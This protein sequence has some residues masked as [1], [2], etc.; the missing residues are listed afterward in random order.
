[1]TKQKFE[2]KIKTILKSKPP[3][4]PK[5]CDTCG[6]YS[7]AKHQGIWCSRCSGKMKEYPNMTWADCLI[8]SCRQGSGWVNGL[9]YELGV[10]DIKEFSR[11]WKDVGGNKQIYKWCK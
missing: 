2:N 1:M 4:P 11:L 7:S 3:H 6:S 9:Q 5:F 8:K 10:M